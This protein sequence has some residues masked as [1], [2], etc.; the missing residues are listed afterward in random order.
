MPNSYTIDIKVPV[1]SGTDDPT[2]ASLDS[3]DTTAIVTDVATPAGAWE[4]IIQQS[5]ESGEPAL[6]IM[7]KWVPDT[8]GLSDPDEQAKVYQFL[9]HFT[10]VQ[11][12]QGLDNVMSMHLR[13]PAM[14]LRGVQVHVDPTMVRCRNLYDFSI[15]VVTLMQFRQRQTYSNYSTAQGPGQYHALNP[16]DAHRRRPQFD[17]YAADDPSRKLAAFLGR[18][19]TA[20]MRLSC[21]IPGTTN[22]NEPEE[23]YSVIPVHSC[24]LKAADT[25]ARRLMRDTASSQNERTIADYFQ[26]LLSQGRDLGRERLL[27]QAPSLP[28]TSMPLEHPRRTGIVKEIRFVDAIPQAVEAV[29]HFMYTGQRPTPE[30]YSHYTVKDLMELAAYFDL[31]DLQDHCIALALGWGQP[32]S[33]APV[34]YRQDMENQYVY[35]SAIAELLQ[36]GQGSFDQVE[37]PRQQPPF[38]VDPSFFQPALP[39]LQGVCA[40]G[41]GPSRMSQLSPESLLQTLFDWGHRFPRMRWAL[42]QALC[43]D[44]GHVF[45]HADG[46]SRYRDHPAYSE[47]LT[48]MIGEQA[49]MVSG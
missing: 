47:I 4:C 38:S 9:A 8:A 31:P 41:S 18:I 44:H 19:E 16:L 27:A 42:V 7:L 2:E 28:G 37:Q 39:L 26:R 24:I 10:H 12:V 32:W 13:R 3:T 20:D 34:V 1:L 46:F 40:S 11:V 15:H 35:A 22:N 6:T 14:L 43:R 29:T 30:P 36:D 25:P 23:H 5:F 21:M 45:T 17:D 33:G 49:R 48:E